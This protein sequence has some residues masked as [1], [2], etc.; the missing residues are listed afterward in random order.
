IAGREVPLRTV[1]VRRIFAN[2]GKRVGRQPQSEPRPLGSVPQ[3]ASS[4]PTPRDLSRK[5]V[6]DLKRRAGG[7][8]WRHTLLDA[9]SGHREISSPLR[10]AMDDHPPANNIK[11][12]VVDDAGAG[13]KTGLSGEV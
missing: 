10:V 12:P 4:A 8:E 1:R 13:V 6:A 3:R 2:A 5:R 7:G 11:H 9:V